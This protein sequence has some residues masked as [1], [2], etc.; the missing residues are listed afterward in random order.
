MHSHGPT[1]LDI[2]LSKDDQALMLRQ[3]KAE[4]H[5]YAPQAGYVTFHVGS[6]KD[7]EAA[8]ELVQLAYN[9]AVKLVNSHKETRTE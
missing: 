3:G 5:R 1:Y 2:R 4:P 7:L 9:N 6:E 8:K